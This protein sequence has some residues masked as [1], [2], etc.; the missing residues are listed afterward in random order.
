MITPCS[1]G[2][3]ITS[4]FSQRAIFILW[5]CSTQEFNITNLT[6]AVGIGD[7]LIH[8]SQLYILKSNFLK[9][10]ILEKQTLLPIISLFFISVNLG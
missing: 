7:R 5:P 2:N 4:I 6:F 8:S 3:L 1:L 9:K 10:L